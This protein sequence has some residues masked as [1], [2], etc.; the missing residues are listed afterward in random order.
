MSK[1]RYKTGNRNVFK[2]LGL[3]N[4]EEHFV[5]AQLV[6]KIDTLIKERGLKQIGGP[7]CWASNN[8]MSPRCCAESF[9]SFPWSAS[10]VFS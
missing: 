6:F 4:A 10:C 8:P 7:F 3:P 9:G 2:D 1:K 5:K